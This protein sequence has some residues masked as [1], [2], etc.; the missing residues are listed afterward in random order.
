M[1]LLCTHEHRAHSN[2]EALQ[3]DHHIQRT[4][5]VIIICHPLSSVIL[6][7][8]CKTHVGLDTWL[9]NPLSVC[10]PCNYSLHLYILLLKIAE[11]EIQSVCLLGSLAGQNVWLMRLAC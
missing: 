4:L 8:T 11:L 2:K 9:P 7:P 6:T 3:V 5:H 1:T 10:N